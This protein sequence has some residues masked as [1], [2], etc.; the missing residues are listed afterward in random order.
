MIFLSGPPNYGRGAV[1]KLVG[2]PNPEALKFA[3]I[4]ADAEAQTGS[5]AQ[6]P[7]SLEGSL[8]AQEFEVG[9]K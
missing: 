8:I 7:K 6:G 1:V 4:A 2:K 5:Q 3:P 9:C